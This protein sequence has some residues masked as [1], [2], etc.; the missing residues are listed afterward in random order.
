MPR[1]KRANPKALRKA[2]EKALNIQLAVKAYKDPSNNLSSRAVAAIFN[3]SK[4][5]I[6][7]HLNNTPDTCKIQYAP[8]VYVERQKL[9]PT[10]ET[11]LCNHIRECYELMLPV[12]VEL[13]HYYAN[14]LLRER[15]EDPVR[16]NWHLAF[17]ECNPSVKTMRARPMEKD[18]VVNE[19]PDNYIKWFRTFIGVVD[20]WGIVPE[21]IYNMDE[22]G[23]GI[24]VT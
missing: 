19:D 11:A 22:S 3:C 18:R 9:T 23:A 8:D 13:L 16:E 5:L 4:S 24:G 7:N 14:E 12:D 10:E 20:K 17:Y 2:A 21:D 1:V 15:G 6:T